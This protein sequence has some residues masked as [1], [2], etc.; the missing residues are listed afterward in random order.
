M[1]GVVF[2]ILA[3]FFVALNS[4]YTKK[5]LNA[6]DDN[7][8]KL[9]LYNNL[10]A[11]VI[12][13]PMIFFFGEHQVIVDFEY[14]ISPYFWFAMFLGGFLGFSMGY[15]TG[16][17][18]QVTSPLTHNVSGTAKAYVQ[19]LIGVFIY[20]EIKTLLWW[21]SNLLV[22]IGAGLYTHVRSIEMKD[23]H[24]RSKPVATASEETEKFVLSMDQP[25]SSPSK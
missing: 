6:V 5:S 18:I 8:W 14:L 2:G 3:S 24:S 9:T 13:V 23:K 1:F 4:I 10:N 19:T 22:L 11:C 17:Q 16:L 12:F 7:V 21:L 20:N 25:S 15:V